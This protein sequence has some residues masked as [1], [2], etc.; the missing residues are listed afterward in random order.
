[1]YDQKKDAMGRV[2]VGIVTSATFYSQFQVTYFNC[3][4]IK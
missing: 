1:M 4:D 2:K 3:K